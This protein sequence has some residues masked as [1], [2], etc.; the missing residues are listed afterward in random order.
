MIAA[1][2]GLVATGIEIIPVGLLA[3]Q[4]IALAAN[5]LQSDTFVKSAAR[6]LEYIDSNREI[7]SEHVYPHV[8]IT[9]KA[10]PSRDRVSTC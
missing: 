9:E 10:F 5:G 7:S 1:G 4:A 6:L 3:G 8:K 2:R